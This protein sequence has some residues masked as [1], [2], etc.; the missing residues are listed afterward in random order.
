MGG[1]YVLLAVWVVCQLSLQVLKSI[2]IT[3]LVGLYYFEIYLLRTGHGRNQQ[4]SGN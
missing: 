2:G 3:A 4:N 1:T